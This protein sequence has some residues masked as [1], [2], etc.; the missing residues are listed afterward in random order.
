MSNYIDSLQ[1]C[2]PQ[3]PSN[4]IGSSD[5]KEKN[6]KTYE[7][8]PSDVLSP[9]MY[10][11]DGKRLIDYVLVYEE[12]DEDEINDNAEGLELYLR[13]EKHKESLYEE[14]DEEEINDNAEGLELFLRREKH[15]ESRETFE[16]NLK[17]LGL[18]LERHDS[19]YV[20]CYFVLV[21]APFQVLCKQAELLKIKMPVFL[22]DAKND[23]SRTDG[24]VTKLLNKFTFLEFDQVILRRI[25]AKDYFTQPFIEKHLDCFVNHDDQPNFF[26]RTER[27]RMVY[28]LLIRTPY[29]QDNPDEFCIGIER[30][31][32]NG[33]YSAAYP[34]H[35]VILIIIF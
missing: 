14:I 26:P 31:I 11:A 1:A 8:T 2:E 28:D 19:F 32:K 12:I 9:S 6:G 10:F 5:T 35:D 21:H 22:N 7:K 4:L 18:E 17:R 3:K 20:N 25:Q 27:S 24:F 33:I 29:D 13:R 16:R 34:L 15:K 23:N 30:M